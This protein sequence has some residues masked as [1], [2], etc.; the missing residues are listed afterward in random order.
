MEKNLNFAPTQNL[1]SWIRYARCCVIITMPTT[2]NKTYCQWIL[3]FNHFVGGKTHPRDLSIRDSYRLDFQLR[4][5]LSPATD[6]CGSGKK[7]NINDKHLLKVI[8]T[9]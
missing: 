1:S 7:M 3:R 2:P 6:D 4:A 8:I 9:T 5:C